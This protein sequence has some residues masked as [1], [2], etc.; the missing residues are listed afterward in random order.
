MK[1]VIVI[2]NFNYSG[3]PYDGSATKTRNIYSYL[4]TNLPKDKYYVTFFNYE[5]WSKHVLRFLFGFRKAIKKNEIF[6]VIPY[7]FKFFYYSMKRLLKNKRKKGIRVFYPVTG[8]WMLDCVM[9]SK[10]TVE[11]MNSM[12]GFLCETHGLCEK[13]GA[14]GCKNIFY[15]PVFSLRTPLSKEMVNNDIS[16]LSSTDET[17]ICT[18]SRVCKNKGIS[19][20]CQA[21]LSINSKRSAIKKI[22]LDIFGKLDPEYKAELDSFVSQSDGSIRYLGIIDD[23]KVVTTLSKYNFCVF[24]SYF[25]WECFPASVLE[26]F[27][28][29][30]PVIASSW[31]YN[32]EIVTDGSTGLI[33]Q[34][35]DEKD[36]EQ[37]IEWAIDNKERMLE[38]RQKCVIE[39]IRF[40]PEKSLE[41]LRALIVSGDKVGQ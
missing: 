25:K 11:L 8:S 20:A 14:C 33:F 29:G 36:L 4:Q 16:R 37:K 27:M 31:L 32:P 18:F 30:T 3:G 35:E 12:D 39:A 40:A 7:S 41:P 23:S 1:N 5:N 38:M 21:V 9:N 34:S 26:S 6:V 19:L 2:G 24:A 17:K 28:A 15:S 13:M 10:S 22:S